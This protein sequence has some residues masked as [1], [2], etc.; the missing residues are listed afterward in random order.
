VRNLVA[1]RRGRREVAHRQDTLPVTPALAAPHIRFRKCPFASHTCS[2]WMASPI[3]AGGT[4][5]LYAPLNPDAST[6]LNACPQWACGH[7]TG[8]HPYSML[9]PGAVRHS[10]LSNTAYRHSCGREPTPADAAVAWAIAPV[11][12]RVMDDV[13]RA[14]IRLIYYNYCTRRCFQR[15]RYLDT[16][17]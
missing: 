5:S 12:C 11:W 13:A 10:T 4:A 1:L 15:P 8:K 14:R 9:H 6:P 16:S 17:K 3:A 7:G 2:A